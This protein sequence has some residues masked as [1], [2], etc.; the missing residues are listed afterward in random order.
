MTKFCAAPLISRSNYAR[1]LSK[2][3]AVASSERSTPPTSYYYRSRSIRPW[4]LSKARAVASSE[5]STSP[6]SSYYGSLSI[7]YSD[8]FRYGVTRRFR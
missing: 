4:L 6:T 8:S 2:A 7:R 1:L 3:R 5:R